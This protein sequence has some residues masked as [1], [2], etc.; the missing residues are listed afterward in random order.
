M[1]TARDESTRDWGWVLPYSLA[2]GCWLI[3]I[4][5]IVFNVWI[6]A[7]LSKP[8]PTGCVSLHEDCAGHASC[9]FLDTRGVLERGES[10]GAPF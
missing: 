10:S 3:L 4:A 9:L 1:F 5:F 2:A 8:L 7:K 6:E